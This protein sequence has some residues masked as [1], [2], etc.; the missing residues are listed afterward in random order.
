MRVDDYRI[1]LEVDASHARWAAFFRKI[2]CLFV[3]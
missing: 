2:W 1:Q 3:R